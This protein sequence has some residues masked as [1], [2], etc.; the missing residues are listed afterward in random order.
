MHLEADPVAQPMTESIAVP[1][2]LYR[3]AS[4]GI[5]SLAASPRRHLLKRSRLRGLNKSVDLAGMLAGLTRREG[6]SPI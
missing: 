3:L 6:A 5:H 4:D 1:A 2:R